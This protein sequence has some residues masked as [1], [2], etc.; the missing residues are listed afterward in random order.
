[1]RKRQRYHTETGTSWCLLGIALLVIVCAPI[2]LGCH[3]LVEAVRA[4]KRGRRGNG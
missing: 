3:Y 4:M 1:M 2:V